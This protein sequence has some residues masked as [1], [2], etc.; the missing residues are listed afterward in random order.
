MRDAFDLDDKSTGQLTMVILRMSITPYLI[1]QDIYMLGSFA[2][3][4]SRVTSSLA[5]V[6]Q[7]AS[8]Q[9]AG[10]VS[11]LDQNDAREQR[12]GQSDGSL[13][14]LEQ[15]LEFIQTVDKA[16]KVQHFHPPSSSS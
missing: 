12:L 13:P 2:G 14:G 15:T 9:Q 1:A 11:Y 7:P 6:P 4:F 3:I 10:Q 16:I 8:M 5:P